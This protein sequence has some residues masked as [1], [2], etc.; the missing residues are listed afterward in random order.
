VPRPA[1]RAQVPVPVVVQVPVPVVVLV[2]VL[3]VVPVPVLV[4]GLV[5]VPGVAVAMRARVPAL[6]AARRDQ[7]SRSA[8]QTSP[9]MPPTRPWWWCHS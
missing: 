9:Q 7:A 8:G 2:P 5:P 6:P 1:A 4:P 3:V